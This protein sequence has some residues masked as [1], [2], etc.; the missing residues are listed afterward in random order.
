MEQSPSWELNWFSAC[1]DIPLMLWSLKV[2]YRIHKNPPPVPILSQ[3]DL[4]PSPSPTSRF[5]RSLS[6]L[7]SRLSLG[8]PSVFSLR[9]PHQNSVYA[10]PLHHTRYMLRPSHSSRFYHPNNTGWGV[11]IVNLLTTYEYDISPI[12]SGNPVHTDPMLSDFRERFNGLNWVLYPT[13]W[14]R[15]QKGCKTLWFEETGTKF[16][17]K[18][19]Y[20]YIYITD[21]NDPMVLFSTARGLDLSATFLCFKPKYFVGVETA[22]Q[23]RMGRGPYAMIILH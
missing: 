14:T 2:H 12:I 5:P 1:Q 19:I 23:R 9:F 16:D 7:S 8:L 17:V 18:K 4:F 21:S 22:I 20:I 11:Q 13:S 3:S 15:K 10:S 6:I